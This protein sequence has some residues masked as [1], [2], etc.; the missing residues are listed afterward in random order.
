MKI[1]A[2]AAL[3]IGVCL[4]LYSSN[5]SVAQDD[6]PQS[7][8]DATSMPLAPVGTP[9]CGPVQNMSGAIA[10]N[11]TWQAG[12]VYVVTGSITV[13]QLTTDRKSVV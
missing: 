4:F 13:N 11:T 6:P 2:V 10:T 3:L 12:K 1:K 5:L 7:V 9:I 8:P